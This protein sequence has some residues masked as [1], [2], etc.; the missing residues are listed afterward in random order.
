MQFL[1][2][3]AAGLASYLFGAIWYMSLAGRWMKAAGIKADESGRPPNS[4][5]APYLV[6]FVCSVLVAGMMRHVFSLGGIDTLGSGLVAGLGIGLFLVAPWI[7]TNYVFADRNRSLIWIDGGFAVG[8][9]TIIG[10]VLT[11]F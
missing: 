11:A 7:A 2:V 6:A 9:C 5:P 4:G 8:G 1:I 3:I 10:L